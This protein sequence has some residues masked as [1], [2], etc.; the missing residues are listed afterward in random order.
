MWRTVGGNPDRPRRRRHRG[1]TLGSGDTS[2]GIGRS[3]GFRGRLLGRH[4]VG[5]VT[6]HLA[7]GGLQRGLGGRH[8]LLGGSYVS[9]GRVSGL[10]G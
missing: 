2:L 7:K 10:L 1:S 8:I 3:R 4:Q 9:D 6:L 5:E